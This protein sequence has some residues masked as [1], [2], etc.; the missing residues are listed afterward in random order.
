MLVHKFHTFE[1]DS[2]ERIY[3]GLEVNQHIKDITPDESDV[4]DYYMDKVI[5]H[6]NFKL[7]DVNLTDL[8][9]DA[10]FKEYYDSGESRYNDD[11]ADFIGYMPHSDEINNAIVIV[12]GE[13]LDGYNRASEL[14][15]MGEKTISAFVAIPQ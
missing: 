14:L 15:R 1:N 11:S 8:L 9:Q 2:E 5:K 7:Q 10:D 12:D 6:R 4:P 3:T 13:V